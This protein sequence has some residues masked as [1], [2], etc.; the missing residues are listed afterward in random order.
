MV[1][2]QL[3][4]PYSDILAVINNSIMLHTMNIF[5]TYVLN[6]VELF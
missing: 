1:I 4:V 3:Q 6:T 5:V 2:E